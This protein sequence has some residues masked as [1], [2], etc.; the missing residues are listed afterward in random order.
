MLSANTKIALAVITI[1]TVPTGGLVVL[2]IRQSQGSF[3]RSDGVEAVQPTGPV[4]PMEAIV[5]QLR[6]GPTDKDEHY[7]RVAFDLEMKNEADRSLLASRMSQVNDCLLSYFS[8][9]TAQQLRGAGGILH[10]KE[11]VLVR[12]KGVLSG[13]TPKTVY[14]TDFLI[15]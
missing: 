13:H 8:D 6:R 5:L 9:L 1:N 2:T 12:L 7:L 4:F 3:L 10:V 14:I 15:Q 11:A